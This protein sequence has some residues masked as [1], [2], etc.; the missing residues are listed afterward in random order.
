MRALV[1]LAAALVG[2]APPPQAP[3]AP[4]AESVNFS[5]SHASDADELL[6]PYLVEALEAERERL[7]AK[8]ATLA[9]G[10]LPVEVVPT[11]AD[12]DRRTSLAAKDVAAGTPA[13]CEGGRLVLVSPRAATGGYPWIDAAVREYGRCAV[14]GASRGRPAT[15]PLR[16][17]G[18]PPPK[19]EASAKGELVRDYARLGDILRARGRHLPA[20]IEYD[21][22]VRRGGLE[23]PDVVARYAQTALATGGLGPAEEPLRAAA[24]AHPGHAG[25]Q[26][27]LGKV[28]AERGE[29]AAARDAYAAALRV[30]PFDAEV[31]AGLAFALE[32]LGD[33][34]GASR[35]KRVT[36]MLRR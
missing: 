26:A 32:K 36:E 22:A 2:A 23:D 30:N 5:V 20:R 14:A 8:G 17:K 34:T 9:E 12:L 18:A 4:S 31:H 35:E 27:A 28:E 33:A 3:P 11:P 1:A 25:V 13:A 10:Q 24:R 29:F 6:G 7:A 15:F 21:K 19:R 16:W